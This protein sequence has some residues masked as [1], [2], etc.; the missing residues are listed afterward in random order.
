M[1]DL[2]NEVVAADHEME[3]S[4]S[5]ASEALAKHRWHWTLDESN[6]DR[7]SIRAYAQAVGRA[8]QT[9]QKYVNGYAAWQAQSGHAGVPTLGEAIERAQMS[10]EKA[11]MV[12]A[13][14]E[15]NPTEDELG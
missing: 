12:E 6:P 4:A 13:V 8:K 5:K 1:T 14:A 11:T 15:A 2:P 7:V 10:A 3:Q 9:I